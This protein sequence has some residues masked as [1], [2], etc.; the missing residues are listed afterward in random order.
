MPTSSSWTSR[1][2]GRSAPADL[3]Q[4]HAISPYIGR[5]FRGRVRRTILRGQ[6]IF[7][8]GRVTAEAKGRFVRPEQETEMQQLGQTRSA[9]VRRP[10]SADAGHVCARPCPGIVNGMAIVHMAPARGGPASAIH[11]GVRGRRHAQPAADQRFAYV[12]EGEVLAGA[13]QR[14][15]REAI[16]V[17]SGRMR[18]RHF[19]L[20]SAGP[21]RSD[22]KAV[23][24]R[25]RGLAPPA[26]FTGSESPVKP[27]PLNGNGDAQVRGLVPD[28]P[29]FDFARQH[30]DLPA[31]AHRSRG[32]DARDGARPADARRRRHLSS[33][34]QLVSGDGRAISSG[35][36]RIARSGSARSARRPRST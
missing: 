2:R 13:A 7:T 24:S 30:D 33:G 3:L 15:S 34:R 36:R 19:A 18:H 12:L 25:W 10:S 29:A 6:T 9:T 11:R 17:P 8:D 28:E 14:W 26:V 31:R 20:S 1:N 4:R 21:A 22:R 35:W 23:S 32:R 5:T 16:V 27:E